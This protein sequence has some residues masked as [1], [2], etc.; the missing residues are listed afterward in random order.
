MTDWKCL[1]YYIS[2]RKKKKENTRAAHEGSVIPVIK[3]VLAGGGRG[4]GGGPADPMFTLGSEWPPAAPGT[5]GL[6][7]CR[8]A[9]LGGYSGGITQVN[10]FLTGA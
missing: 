6:E 3:R 4:G 5:R 10:M 1:R 9:G 2:P 8:L 7:Y